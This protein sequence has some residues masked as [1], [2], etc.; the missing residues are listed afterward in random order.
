MKIDS[1][2]ID[3]GFDEAVEGS[4]KAEGDKAIVGHL[5]APHTLYCCG[6]GTNEWLSE[7]H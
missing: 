6:R 5:S 7:K 3:K 2:K 4:E 1:M